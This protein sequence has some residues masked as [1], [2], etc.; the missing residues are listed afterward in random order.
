MFVLRTFSLIIDVL[1]L[2]FI[3]LYCLV[4][5]FLSVSLAC[6]L[7]CLLASL[8]ACLLA[9]LLAFLF[10][11][12]SLFACL[13]VCQF[14]FLFLCFLVCLL[15]CLFVCLSFSCYYMFFIQ[16]AWRNPAG[17]RTNADIIFISYLYKVCHA[18]LLGFT[19]SLLFGFGE[20]PVQ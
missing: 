11:L 10:F 6:L 14:D 15:A 16:S 17:R 20:Q 2:F 3:H 5:L 12:F 19:K 4:F 1:F 8:L 9:S 13:F 7:V 18:F